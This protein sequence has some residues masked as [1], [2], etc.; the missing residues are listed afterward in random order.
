[1]IRYVYARWYQHRRGSYEKNGGLTLKN[2]KVNPRSRSL[3]LNFFDQNFLKIPRTLRKIT[4][5]VI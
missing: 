4:T 3:N 2:I 5:A 1:M